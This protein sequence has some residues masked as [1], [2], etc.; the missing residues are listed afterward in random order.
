MCGL[1]TGFLRL[2]HNVASIS[3]VPFVSS[4]AALVILRY[5]SQLILG[6]SHLFFGSLGRP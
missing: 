3:L 4:I 2:L 5:S 1:S 6:S